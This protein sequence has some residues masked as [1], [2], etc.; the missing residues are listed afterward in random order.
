MPVYIFTYGS[1]GTCGTTEAIS[2]CEAQGFIA[3]T[4][5]TFTTSP[6]NVHTTDRHHALNWFL[7]L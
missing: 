7:A 6:G 3:L 5:Y 2:W 4:T 1:D